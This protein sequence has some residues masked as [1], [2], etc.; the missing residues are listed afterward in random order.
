MS[1]G[2]V[3]LV[4]AGP[5]DPGLITVRGCEVL[6]AADAVL[7]DHLIAPELLNL[8]RP[9]AERISVGKSAGHHTLPQDRINALL[10]DK[11][12][13]GLCVVRLKGGDCF[14]FGRGGEEALACRRAGIPCEVVPGVTSAL[15][16]PCYAGIPVT[17]RD[18]TS[19][20]AVVTGHRKEAGPLQIPK[21]GTVIFLMSVG[22]LEAIVAALL[23]Q[24]WPPETPMAAVE[25]G[26]CYDQRVITGQIANFS[27]RAADAGL[28]PPAVVVV[29]RVV[30]L[31]PS[32]DWFGTK[33]RVLVLGHHPHRYSHLGHIVHRRMIDCRPMEDQ[34]QLD[35]V[36]R[37]LSVFDWIVFTSV[38]GARIF[39]D[40]LG[41]GGRDAR[42][43]GSVKIAAIGQTTARS[44]RS[45]GLCADLIPSDESSK[46]L[47]AEFAKL[48]LKGKHILLPRARVCSE[49]LTQGL[50]DQG[51]AIEKV[52]VYQTV[53]LDPGEID[54][55]HIDAV[56]FTSGST[57]RAFARRFKTVPPGIQAWCLGLPTLA[58]ARHHGIHA[59][60]MPH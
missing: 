25:R 23:D 52:V 42:V 8:A 31:H 26:T 28:Q 7:Y 14:L 43:L 4:G 5:G 45:F 17:H 30:D 40:R 51:A 22:N 39:F 27:A 59:D 56:L 53:D 3:Y 11:A 21:A 41:A 9:E 54:F 10:V 58:E 46:G 12:G 16:A 29:G 1:Q 32:L 47:L 60:L 24:G 57:V 2:K 19:D 50:A 15:A 13:A 35:A 34:T 38:N 49:E 37:D 33:R 18:Y 36:Q 44:L 20:V 55:G 6:A 48:D